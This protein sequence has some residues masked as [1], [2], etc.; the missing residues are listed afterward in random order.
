MRC[1]NAEHSTK[2]KKVFENR[3]SGS[4]VGARDTL[5]SWAPTRKGLAPSWDVIPKRRNAVVKC[6]I[7]DE[8]F[9]TENQLAQH[10]ASMHAGESPMSEGGAQQ[11]GDDDLEEPDFKRASGE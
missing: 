11:P 7:C 9:D 5:F 2:H 3:I 6:E 10:K 1:A 8:E 4:V